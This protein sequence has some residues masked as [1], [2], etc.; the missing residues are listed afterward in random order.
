MSA[1]LPQVLAAGIFL[2]CMIAGTARADPTGLWRASDGGT[3]RI[4]S[5]GAALCGYIVSVVPKI[6]PETSKPATDKN[7]VDPS[8]RDRP[9]VGVSILNNMRFDAPGRWTGQLY[10]SDRGQFFLGHLLEIDANTIRIEG[11]AL[12]ICGGENLNH[13]K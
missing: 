5:C 2:A 13:V 10:D 8:K 1:R 12:G 11:C 9:L 6:D 4:S 7:N 3:I